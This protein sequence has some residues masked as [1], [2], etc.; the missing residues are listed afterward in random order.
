MQATKVPA[1]WLDIAALTERPEKRPR[2]QDVDVKGYDVLLAPC[3]WGMRCDVEQL[4]QNLLADGLKR[5]VPT[6][7]P[8]RH[9][10]WFRATGAV[11]HRPRDRKWPFVVPREVIQR[12]VSCV[13][14]GA[15]DV[16]QLMWDQETVPLVVKMEL[17]LDTTEGR[18]VRAW[19]P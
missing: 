9:T 17:Y 12:V 18:C 6:A 16:A 19:I 11:T 7:H 10:L 8:S 15:N 1:R 3:V 14:A 4:H 13:S 5:T 2:E